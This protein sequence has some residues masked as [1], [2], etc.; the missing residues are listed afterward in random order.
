MVHGKGIFC[1]DDKPYTALPGDVFLFRPGQTLQWENDPLEPSMSQAIGLYAEPLPKY[2]PPPS[3]WPVRR[4]LPDNDVIRPL[5]EFILGN[6]PDSS[7]KPSPVLESAIET[8][9]SAFICGP[10]IRPQIVPSAYPAAVQRVVNSILQR[11]VA[12]SHTKVTLDD[13]AAIGGV[14]REHLCRLFRQYVGYSP[15]D[16]VYMYRLTRSLIGLNT[17]QTVEALAHEFG[18]ADAPH[19]V[20]RFIALF[21]K[22]PAEMRQAMA[23]GYKPKLPKL[24]EMG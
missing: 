22:S 16:M 21:G 1:V 11:L 2:W 19:Y 18:F 10:V 5:F 12:R 13:L 7:G 8:M 4:R 20:R 15:V 6:A 9:M 17:G 23:K 3:R 14:S 24:P